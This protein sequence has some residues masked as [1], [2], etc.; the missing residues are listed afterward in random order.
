MDESVSGGISAQRERLAGELRAHGASFTELGRRFATEIGVHA[1]DAF[2]LLDTASAEARGVPPSPALLSS[3][4]PLS[5]E[6]MT[7]PLDRLERA[8]YVVR[9]R[10]HTD[11]RIVTL[12]STPRAKARADAFFGPVNARQDAVLSG[13]PSELLQQGETVL[14]QLRSTTDTRLTQQAKDA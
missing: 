7:A 10:E 2:A 9:T 5:S 14:T 11:R 4:I 3:G 6:A 12:R 1:T 13:H 8:G